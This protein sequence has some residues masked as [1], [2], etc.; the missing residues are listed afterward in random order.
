MCIYWY[1][2][3]RYLIDENHG[4]IQYFSSTQKPE[5]GPACSA[6]RVRRPSRTRCIYWH[7]QKASSIRPCCAVAGEAEPSSS[8]RIPCCGGFRAGVRGRRAGRETRERVFA[9][10]AAHPSLSVGAARS[11]PAVRSGPPC[12]RA[13][14]PWKQ[15][16]QP[17][18]H[19]TRAVVSAST[20]RQA[21][22]LSVGHAWSSPLRPA[23]LRRP[24]SVVSDP[25]LRSPVGCASWRSP[26]LRRPHTR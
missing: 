14:W 17:S 6:S 26:P 23:P 8:D 13:C 19:R 16:A 25:A 12:G 21:R 11:S 9:V 10:E 20:L 5:Q 1:H 24:H 22:R 15:A 3:L 7:T 4:H 2:I 18:L